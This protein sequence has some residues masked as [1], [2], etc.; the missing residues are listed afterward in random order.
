[1]TLALL[2]LAAEVR[3]N[4]PGDSGAPGPS[5]GLWLIVKGVPA[6]ASRL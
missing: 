2:P 5:L 6:A 4:A 1:M 3:S